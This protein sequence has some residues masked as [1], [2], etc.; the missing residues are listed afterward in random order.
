[1]D[2]DL[3]KGKKIL[4]IGAGIA[5]FAK[6]AKDRGI[7]VV[8]LDLHET[9]GYTGGA[10]DNRPLEKK[11]FIRGKAQELPFEDGAFDLVISK[12]AP[13]THGGVFSVED[14][15]KIISEARRVLKDGGEF[16]FGP[17]SLNMPGISVPEPKAAKGYEYFRKLAE[18]DVEKVEKSYEFLKSIDPDIGIE[19]NGMTISDFGEEPPLGMI[20]AR[21]HYYSLTKKRTEVD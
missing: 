11:F 16:R 5:G 12:G 15:K 10:F 19:S 7:D 4:D 13:P 3:L 21:G 9:S 20:Y 1:M 14:V 2:W 6:V 17:A 8:S 18:I